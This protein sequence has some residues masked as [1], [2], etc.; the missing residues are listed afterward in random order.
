MSAVLGGVLGAT[1]RAGGAAGGGAGGGG[2]RGGG[3]G[4]GAGTSYRILGSSTAQEILHLT[5]QLANGGLHGAT[6]LLLAGNAE[7]S[8]N[9][10]ES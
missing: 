7:R 4:G 2:H 6:R 1:S 9:V 8:G 3:G 5:N 10:H